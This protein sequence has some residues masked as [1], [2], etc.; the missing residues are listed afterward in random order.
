MTQFASTMECVHCG[1]AVDIPLSE[2]SDDDLPVHERTDY[3]MYE[4]DELKCLSCGG[5]NQVMVDDERAYFADC[6]EGCNVCNLID[7]G[8]E[9]EPD[10][11]GVCP[12]C[13]TP[14]YSRDGFCG[15]CE[16]WKR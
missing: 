12:K 7:N 10:P 5:I 11:I 16:P 4:G 2:N 8:E 13:K 9:E 15:V 6:M 1:S 14:I 3:W